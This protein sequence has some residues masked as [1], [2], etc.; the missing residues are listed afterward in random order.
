VYDPYVFLASK[1]SVKEV[2][3]GGDI[4]NISGKIQN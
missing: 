4:M 3:G 2:R 1:N